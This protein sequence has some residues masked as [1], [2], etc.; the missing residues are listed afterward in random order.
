MER[1]KQLTNWIE[2]KLNCNR[3]RLEPVSSDASFRRYY[4]VVLQESKTLVAM[5]APPQHQDCYPFAKVAGLM[6][7]AGIKVPKIIFSDMQNGFLILTDLGKNTYLDIINQN[8]AEK[9]FNSAI[10]T[11]IKWQCATSVNKLPA[12][13]KNLLQKEL[14]L[15]LDWY[16]GVHFSGTLSEDS[17]ISLRSTNDLLIYNAIEQS[18]VFVH[19]DYMPR[20]IMA[21][22]EGGPGIIDFQDAVVGPITYDVVSLF[23]DAFVSWSEKDIARWTKYYWKK[24]KDHNLPVE[25]SFTNFQKQFDLMGVQRH[26]KVLGIFARICYRDKKPKYLKDAPRF[27]NYLKTTCKRHDELTKLH[28]VLVKIEEYSD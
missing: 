15:F 6:A 1:L 2:L 13:S 9:L 16:I 17:I 25:D 10:D 7:T 20:N 4:R 24:A 27:F 22:P 19:R 18:Q 5:D 3:F 23:K 8:N 21:C 28:Q 11:L 26:L 12:Y 14:D